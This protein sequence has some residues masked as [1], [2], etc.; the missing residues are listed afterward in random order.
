MYITNI[1]DLDIKK[2]RVS[3]N[4]AEYLEK[5]G[6][7][8]LGKDDKYFYFIDIPEIRNAIL[9]IPFYIRLFGSYEFIE[10]KEVFV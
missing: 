3:E 2:I 6:F 4:I 5:Q 8:K 1:K 9:D 10:A 7:S